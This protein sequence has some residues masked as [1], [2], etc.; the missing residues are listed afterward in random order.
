MTISVSQLLRLAPH[1]DGTIVSAL[2]PALNTAFPEYDI[3]TIMR[4]AHFIAQICHESAGFTRLIENLNYSA[5]R[6]AEVWQRLAP[7][8]HELEHNPEKLGNAAYG[9]RLGNGP[10]ASGEGYKYRGRGL[11]QIT[12]KDNYRKFGQIAGLNLVATPDFAMDVGTSARIA[13]EFWKS[14]NLNPR[15][16]LDDC[17]AITRAIN[18]GVNGLAE[19]R[20]LADAGKTIFV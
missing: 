18:G 12:G 19:R 11:I 4:R 9:G 16:D 1:A 7:R 15:A 13:L 5:K 3:K 14:R 2:A 17:E 8:A 6:I 10:E 20:R